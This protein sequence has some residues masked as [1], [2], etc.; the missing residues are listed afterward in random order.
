MV[1]MPAE[2]RLR[3]ES[4]SDGVLWFSVRTESDEAAIRDGVIEYAP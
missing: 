4:S 1:P 2:L 3:I